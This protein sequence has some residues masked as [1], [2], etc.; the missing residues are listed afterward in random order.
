MKKKFP[1]Q[2]VTHRD[3]RDVNVELQGEEMK[4]I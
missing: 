4:K 2:P 3:I 1:A